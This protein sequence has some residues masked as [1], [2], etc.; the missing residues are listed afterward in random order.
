MS[1]A[2]ISYP[3]FMT[4]IVVVGKCSSFFIK[5]GKNLEVFPIT[6]SYLVFL[7]RENP[8]ASRWWIKDN[9][10]HWER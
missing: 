8:T 2:E 1:D 4:F 10:G 6:S 5:P 9:F 3:E 7:H